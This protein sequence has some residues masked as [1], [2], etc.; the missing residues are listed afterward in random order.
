MKYAGAEGLSLQ[1]NFIGAVLP[2]CYQ[3][4]QVGSAMHVA[5]LLSNLHQSHFFYK[6]LC[7]FREMQDAMYI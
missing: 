2:S 4:A 3:I 1:A 5:V 6:L 7:L